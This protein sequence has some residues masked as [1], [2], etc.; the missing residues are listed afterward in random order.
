MSVFNK[1][2]QS[3]STPDRI[4]HNRPINPSR[5]TIAQVAA[6]SA[7]NRAKQQMGN[8][9]LSEKPSIETIPPVLQRKLDRYFSRLRQIYPD[10]V[11]VR[12]NTGQKK[13]AERGSQLRHMLHWEQS[14]DEFFAL[15]GFSYQRSE[16]GRPPTLKG[17]NDIAKLI[18][19]IHKKFPDGVPSIAAIDKT[20]HRL[21]LDLRSVAR[22]NSCTITQFI[23]E[24][25]IYI[26][27]E[28]A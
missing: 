1:W 15:G 4:R 8:E 10:G 26:L 25:N 3:Q 6:S 7:A 21:Y 11:I 14:L 2:I 5:K 20:D 17:E 13:L 24:N 12:L 22:K 9:Q 19:R 27:K 16:S 28:S 23:K 18:K